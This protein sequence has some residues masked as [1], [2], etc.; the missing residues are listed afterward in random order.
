ML[1]AV[2]GLTWRGLAF[3]VAGAAGF[4]Y[5]LFIAHTGGLVRVAA[6]ALALPVVCVL[7]VARIRHQLTCTR[8]IE[9]GRVQT[10]EEAV[11]RLRLE[12]SSMVPMS[13][14]VAEDVLPTTIRARARF[15]IARLEPHGRREVFYR[16]R[17]ELRGRYRIGPAIALVSDPF[18]MCET[19]RPF[20]ETGD[21]IVIPVVEDL[22]AVLLGGEWTG[23][24]DSHPTSIPS[25]GEDDLG[26]REYH[27][28]D[29]LHRVHW[30]AT[31]R[32]GEL[33]VRREEQPR[34]SRALILLDAR[35]VAHRGHGRY[36]SVEWAVSAAASLAVHLT[37]RGYS[38][39]MITET[40]DPVVGTAADLLAPVPD[41]EGLLLDGLAELQPSRVISL[42]DAGLT[43][44]RFG[45]DSLVIAV[46]GAITNRDAEDLAH[47]RQGTTTAIAI[48][49]RYWT[50]GVGADPKAEADFAHGATVLRAAGWRVIEASAGDKL[51]QL[52]PRAARG[53]AGLDRPGRF[54]EAGT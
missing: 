40:G 23:G 35:A 54:A 8:V 18:G 50:W 48:L 46:L 26:V 44:G 16:I 52:W 31:A 39:R 30:R 3:A 47:R 9:P 17:S 6:L 25:A 7:A 29:P 45:S 20:S 11:V 51:A 19:A 24:D 34:R 22:P 13:R 36:A 53:A 42:R 37:R 49:L 27:H 43:L 5:P 28:G 21:L 4:I 10:G 41:I 33:M 1:A 15:T 32:R 38:A 12:N 2:R 14:L